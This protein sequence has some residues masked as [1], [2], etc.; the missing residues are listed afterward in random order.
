MRDSDSDDAELFAIIDALPP[1]PEANLKR[2]GLVLSTIR[3]RNEKKGM[4]GDGGRDQGG[5]AAA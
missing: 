1:R 5:S 2:I 4:A 3:A